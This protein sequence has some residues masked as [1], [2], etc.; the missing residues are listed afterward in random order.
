MRTAGNPLE[1]GAPPTVVEAAPVQPRGNL[2]F[3]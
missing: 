2:P 3:V 1:A